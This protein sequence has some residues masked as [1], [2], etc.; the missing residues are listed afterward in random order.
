MGNFPVQMGVTGRDVLN[1]S[2]QS[3]TELLRKEG[4]P[5]N[6]SNFTTVNFS[7]SN[8]SSLLVIPSNFSPYQ[9]IIGGP[10]TLTASDDCTVFTSANGDI[11]G[12]SNSTLQSLF[13]PARTPVPFGGAY[14]FYS[15]NHGFGLYADSAK[16]AAGKSVTIGYSMSGVQICNDLNF[17]AKKKIVWYGDSITAYT[18]NTIGLNNCFPFAVRNWLIANSPKKNSCRLVNMGISGKKGTDF[19]TLWTDDIYNIDDPDIIFWQ[20]GT[21]D[22]SQSVGT[23]A[24]ANAVTYAANYKQQRWPNATMVF[25]GSTPRQDNTAE[26]LL[27]TYRAAEV[28]ALAAFS[29]DPKI[30]YISLANAFDRTATFSTIWASSDT[31]GNGLHP[32]TVLSHTGIVNTITAGL[33]SA[34]VTI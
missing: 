22:A 21:N 27:A 15:L 23:T 34:G 16:A 25:L 32:G 12:I 17:N 1:V 24:F 33:T 19:Q 26:T 20:L 18:W 11:D 4:F 14:P 9:R 10:I 3:V 31:A 29:S 6:V 7:S 2:N 5:F 28:T 8:Q 13:L 30:I